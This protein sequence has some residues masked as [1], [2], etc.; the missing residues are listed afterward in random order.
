MRV[1]FTNEA[2]L[3]KYGLAEGFRQIG[4]QAKVIQGEGERLWGGLPIKE[5]RRRLLSAIRE[6][7]PDFILLRVIRDLT[8]QLFAGPFATFRYLIYTGRL[9]TRFPLIT[10][11]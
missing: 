5:Q 9:R 2:P 11:Q 4:C 8:G 1:L 10:S 7:K 6:F 3:I